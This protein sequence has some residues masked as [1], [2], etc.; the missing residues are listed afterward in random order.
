[1]NP[2]AAKTFRY[3]IEL[4]P[5]WSAGRKMA[6]ATIRKALLRRTKDPMVLNFGNFHRSQKG[7]FSISHTR[8]LGGY[9]LANMPSGFDIESRS[10]PISKRAYKRITTPQERELGLTPIEA[11]VA[12]EAAFKA[13]STRSEIKTITAVN[14]IGCRKKSR[15]PNIEFSFKYSDSN[16]LHIYGQGVIRPHRRFLLGIARLLP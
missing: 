2:P 13:L 1:M 3:Q 11:W 15:G 14:L 10:R 4:S 12:K 7:Y 9:I 16:K 8:G 5:R 6:R